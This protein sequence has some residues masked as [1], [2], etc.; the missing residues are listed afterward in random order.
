MDLQQRKTW[1]LCQALTLQKWKKLIEEDELF[2]K[3]IYIPSNLHTWWREMEERRREKRSRVWLALEWMNELTLEFISTSYEP[4]LHT[5]PHSP[6]L[7]TIQVKRKVTW[8][9]SSQME[10]SLLRKLTYYLRYTR[11]YQELSYST[12][13]TKIRIHRKVPDPSYFSLNSI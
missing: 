9:I 13:Y 11:W 12:K 2:S 5:S 3:P 8:P 1:V 10:L 6:F 4:I 7:F